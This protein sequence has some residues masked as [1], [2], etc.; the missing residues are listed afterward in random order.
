MKLLGKEIKINIDIPFGLFE[1]IQNK[2]EDPLVIKKF[3]SALTGLAQKD[4]R[5]LRI[6]EI[7][8]VMEEFRRLQKEETRESKK[9]LSL[10]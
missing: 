1:D 2:P 6:S 7:T 9:K 4:V 5:K 3:I 8:K 10:L